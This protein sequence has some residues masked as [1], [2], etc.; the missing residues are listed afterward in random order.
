MMEILEIR[1]EVC[2]GLGRAR[3]LIK[4]GGF[5]HVF[6]DISGKEAFEEFLDTANTKFVLIKEIPEK[7]DDRIHNSI[8]RPILITALVNV[9][10][11][12]KNYQIRYTESRSEKAGPFKVT[13]ARTLVVDDNPVNIAVAAGLLKQYGINTDTAVSGE[14]AM[15]KIKKTDYDIIFM[16]HMMP[17]MDGMDT[18]RAV[19]SLGGRFDKLVI[20]ALTANAVSDAREQ[21]LRAGMND[22][23]A[24]P[25]I[26]S[27]L[28]VILQKYLPSN[29]I[30]KW[31]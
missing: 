6:L 30:V 4:A 3:E 5:T 15:V 7:Y 14:E 2:T 18:T 21:F 8:N 25:V 31:T 28:Q 29:K 9:L 1:G 23:L 11:G 13:G 10:S 26:L 12:K 24:K 22:F 20:I 27:E 16:D 17:G 19:R